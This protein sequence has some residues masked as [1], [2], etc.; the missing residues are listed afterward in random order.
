MAALAV[1]MTSCNKFINEQLQPESG[2]TGTIFI[3]ICR[4]A[5]DSDTKAVTT[6]TDVKDYEG[7][8]NNVQVFVF[9][10][11]TGLIHY[12]KDLGT[13]TSCSV[14]IPTGQKIVWAV[15]NGPVLKSI[16]TVTELQDYALDLTANSTDESKG[17]V[18]SG[19]KELNLGTG[20]QTISIAVSRLV[21]RVAL[22]G[23]KNSIPPAYGALVIQKV[24][25]ANVVAN[26]NIAGTASATKWYNQEGRADEA[27]RN[28]AHI[29]DGT[30]Y[31]ASA[32]SLTYKNAGASSIA[33]GSGIGSLSAS[34]YLFYT[35]PNSSTTTGNG[36][37]TTMAAQRSV[38]V[39]A[40]TINGTLNYYPIVLDNAVLERNKTYTV[41]VEI[42]GFGS[43]DP[44]KPVEKGSMDISLSV[45]GWLSGASYEEVI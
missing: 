13:G 43:T 23:I 36:F 5:P 33:N 35:F 27:T 45:S 40:A 20:N 26:Q 22:V 6:Y 2:G 7:N 14:S 42:T 8:V 9:D 15:V 38:L 44:N 11:T 16:K 12:Y 19:Y 31:K 39:I 37:N 3:D 32:E 28:A 17:F 21:S 25:L 18:M 41:G 10:K 24:F 30:T 1:A 34:P 4:T 29:I